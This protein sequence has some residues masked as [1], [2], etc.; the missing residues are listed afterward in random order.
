MISPSVIWVP[1][2]E[3]KLLN[4]WGSKA[5]FHGKT[6]LQPLKNK[7]K[8]K[9]TILIRILFILPL[10]FKIPIMIWIGPKVNS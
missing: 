9:K 10:S 5:V 4:G 1:V 2:S 6:N 8:N 3:K 7:L